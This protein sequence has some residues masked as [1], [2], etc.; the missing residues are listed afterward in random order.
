MPAQTAF[1]TEAGDELNFTILIIGTTLGGI[2]DLK[3]MP[4][5]LGGPGLGSLVVVTFTTAGVGTF[6]QEIGFNLG[7]SAVARPHQL[8]GGL[9]RLGSGDDR[10]TAIG[11]ILAAAAGTGVHIIPP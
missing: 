1:V 6:K 8:L 2:N 11:V 9:G 3:S 7:V 5:G 10:F 4:L